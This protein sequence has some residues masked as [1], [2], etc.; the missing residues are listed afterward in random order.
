MTCS[1]A[2]DELAI[3]CDWLDVTYSPVDFPYPELNLLL[4]EAG[5]EVSKDKGGSRRY[6]PPEGF[7][8][9]LTIDTAPRWARISA[10]GGVCA[11]LRRLGLWEPFLSVLG[12][13][14]HKVTRLDAALDLSIDAAGVI[15]T[16]M[17]RYPDG[18]V[19]LSRKA[20]PVSRLLQVREDGQESGTFYVGHRSAARFTARVYDKSLEALVKRG[21]QLPTTTRFEVTARKDSGATLRDAA[22]PAAIFWH[23]AA[24]ALLKC[25]EGVPMWVPNQDLGWTAPAPSFNPAEVL[26]R[27]VESSAELDAFLQVADTMGPSGRAYLIHLI[28]RRLGGSVVSEDTAEVV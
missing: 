5:F 11:A 25:P 2:S 4:L 10:S 7:R 21:E 28:T 26:Q 17:A 23:I 24:P 12:T 9:A 3:F 8:G 1:P 13:S 20:L 27:R 14:P 16:L 6:E 22:L 19:N 15:R 18:R